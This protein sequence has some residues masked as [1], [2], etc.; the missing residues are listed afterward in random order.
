[1]AKSKVFRELFAECD[2][3]FKLEIESLKRQIQRA[4]NPV[5]MLGRVT[6]LSKYQIKVLKNKLKKLRSL[7]KSV[8]KSLKEV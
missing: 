6:P 1:M 4:E 3:Y 2:E 7:E 5:F 8:H